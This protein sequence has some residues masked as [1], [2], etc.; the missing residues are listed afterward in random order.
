MTSVLFRADGNSQIGLGHVYRCLAVAARLSQDFNCYLAIRNPSIELKNSITGTATLI[1]LDEY[2]TYLEE[3][4][5]LVDIA[6]SYDVRI[7][8]LDGYYFNTAYQKVIKEKSK[9]VLISIDDD[10]PFHYLSDIVINHAAGID[11]RKFS[12]A[13]Y[14]KLFIGY[15]YLL[16]RKEFIKRLYKEKK[17]SA[18]HSILICFGGADPGDFT[19]KTIECLL[20]EK[21]FSRITIVIGSAYNKTDDLKKM[22]L[23]HAHIRMESNLNEK[24]M[25]E[26]MFGSDLAIIP[27]STIS[28]EAFAC[29]MVIITGITAD[30][31]RHIY[32]GLIKEDTVYGIG[33]FNSLSCAGLLSIIE[34]ASNKFKNYIFISERK[35]G[36]LLADLYKSLL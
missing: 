7:I 6:T 25:S 20:N 34:Q 17:I 2:E 30:N 10:Q 4:N 15:D 3:A 33:D 32:E 5:A 1:E 12:K 36:D 26:L 35:D 28:L 9:A 29:K 14:T 13:E 27:A 19:S 16:L 18:I 22:I 23:G 24:E 21:S 8:T 31:Q 11:A